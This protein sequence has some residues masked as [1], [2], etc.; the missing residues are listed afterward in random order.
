V[1]AAVTAAR[2]PL[3]VVAAERV[4]AARAPLPVAAAELVWKTK[5]PYKKRQKKSGV[6]APAPQAAAPAEAPAEA[7][8]PA[9]KTILDRLQLAGRSS[10][11]RPFLR[12]KD[13]VQAI[14]FAHSL[15]CPL[16]K[17]GGANT[18]FFGGGTQRHTLRDHALRGGNEA[19]LPACGIA[20]AHLPTAAAGLEDARHRG[21]AWM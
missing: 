3:P 4:A 21:W 19:T 6:P 15:R 17:I 16:R 20:H 7:P 8:A 9:E 5:R 13:L 2:A 18:Q 14:N 10:M 1:V 11:S 12:P